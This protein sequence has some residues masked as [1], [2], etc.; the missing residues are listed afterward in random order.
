MLYPSVYL[1]TLS[2]KVTS[3]N[4]RQKTEEKMTSEAFALASSPTPEVVVT[5]VLGAEEGGLKRA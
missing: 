4:R 3:P 1:S 5:Q 2:K